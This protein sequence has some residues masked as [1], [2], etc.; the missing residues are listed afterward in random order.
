[1]EYSFALGRTRVLSIRSTSMYNSISRAWRFQDAYLSP[2]RGSFQLSNCFQSYKYIMRHIYNDN[3]FH[4]HIS[5]NYQVWVPHLLISICFFFCKLPVYI[6]WLFFSRC[7]YPFLVD[8]QEFFC[9]PDIN[10]VSV[11]DIISIF[12]HSVYCLFT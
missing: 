12:S 7:C 3:S 5:A 10:S 4:F 11:A 9:I 8:L 2:V 1:M 6:L